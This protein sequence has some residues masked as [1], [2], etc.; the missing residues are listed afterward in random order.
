MSIL[1]NTSSVAAVR[2]SRWR[3]AVRTA[4]VSLLAGLATAGLSLYPSALGSLAHAQPTCQIQDHNV[5]V[6]SGSLDVL[7]SQNTC[8]A[9]NKARLIFQSDGNLVV[10][11]EHMRPVFASNTVG[12]GFRLIFQS[13]GNLVVYNRNGIRPVDAVFSTHTAGHPRDILVVQT[14]GNV[15]IYTC[16]GKVAFATN[17]R[18]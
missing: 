8:W 15:V 2:P 16:E 4:T 10:Y 18:H 1:A 3:H 6:R 11:D 7:A 5:V 13:D 17:T 9:T 14:D 12:R